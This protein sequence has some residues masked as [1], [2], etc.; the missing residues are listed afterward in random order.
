MQRR[1][2]GRVG[3]GGPV[4]VG[5]AVLGVVRRRRRILEHVVVVV[6]VEGDAVDFLLGRAG[7]ARD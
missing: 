4:A 6:D 5:G 7:D 2:R 3:K 1:L